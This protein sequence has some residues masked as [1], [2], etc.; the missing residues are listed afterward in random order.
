[1]SP[2]LADE[3]CRVQYDPQVAFRGNTLPPTQ[4]SMQNWLRVKEG[5]RKDST[6]FFRMGLWLAYNACNNSP[7]NGK[8]K[9][10]T[11]VRILP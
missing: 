6:W 4:S 1:M 2:C 8:R 5:Q 3:A 11:G 10:E 9:L 7:D